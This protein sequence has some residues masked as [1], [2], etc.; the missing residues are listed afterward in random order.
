MTG[1]RPRGRPVEAALATRL[2]A[3]AIGLI[4]QKRSFDAISVEAVCAAAGASKA[5]FY[6]RWKDRDAFV[7]AMMDS[8]R[9]P[10]LPA[11]PTASLEDD[12]VAMIEG[13]FGTDMRRTRIVHAALVMEGRKNRAMIG[14]YLRDVVR[15]RREA[16]TA[17]LRKAAADGEIAADSDIAILHELLTS[18]VLKFMLLTDPDTPVPHDFVPRLVRQIL[19]GAR[20]GLEHGSDPD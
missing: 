18:P 7:V 19:R 20:P 5:S 2:I 3:A 12:L 16:V 1:K 10:P 17:R 9:E 6:R 11:G 4:E 14:A 13:M 8:L 15:P